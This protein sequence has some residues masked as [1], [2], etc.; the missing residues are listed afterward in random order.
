[1]KHNTFSTTRLVSLKVVVSARQSVPLRDHR[2][3][4]A[5]SRFNY[6][7]QFEAKVFT[8]PSGWVEAFSKRHQTTLGLGSSL[9]QTCLFPIFAVPSPRVHTSLSVAA[10]GLLL[11]AKGSRYQYARCPSNEEEDASELAP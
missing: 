3:K 4:V 10:T 9:L 5:D 2:R 8:L 7:C 11:L 1:L 6:L